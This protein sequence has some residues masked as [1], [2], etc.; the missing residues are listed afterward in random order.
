MKGNRFTSVLIP[1]LSLL[2]L[3]VAGLLVTSH[4]R[5]I[6][7]QTQSPG[8][9]NYALLEYM[10]I[11][12]GRAA[13]YRKVE[14]EIWMPIHR[15][16]VKAKLI[17]SWALW[18]VRYPGGTSREYDIVAVTLYDNFKDLE[19]SYPAEI[20][21]KVHPKM[22]TAE[23]GAQT[24]AA[25]KMVR[26]EV[27]S[28]IDFAL[29]GPEDPRSQPAAAPAKYARFDYKKVEFGKGG[30][31]V[32]NE[33]RYY[34]PFWQ[35]H[36]N[37]N[38]LRGWA[39]LGVRFPGGTEREYGFLTIQLFDKFEQLERPSTQNIWAKVHPNVKGEEISAQMGAISRTVRSEV[40]TL[41]DRVQ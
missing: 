8:P 20:Y 33:R 39:V 32:R 29:P 13:D 11:E 2:L 3:F 35:E 15:E 27:V 17:R 7:A 25:R 4:S 41:I 40:L 22:T 1:A 16:R 21:A 18:G 9:P 5:S 28:I 10:K 31:Y 24:S 23:I 12:P 19:T 37:Q 34:K 6:A 14:Q 36:V 26:T 30:D 38:L